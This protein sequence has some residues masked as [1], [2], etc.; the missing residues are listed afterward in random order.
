MLISLW[1]VSDKVTKE[2]MVEFYDQLM[3]TN[4]KRQAYEAAVARMREKYPDPRYW[5]PFIYLGS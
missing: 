3:R 4:N 5:A 2:Y 1:Q